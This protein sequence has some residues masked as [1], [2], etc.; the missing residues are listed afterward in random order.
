MTS[1][2]CRLTWP[3]AEERCQLDPRLFCCSAR[4][5]LLAAVVCGERVTLGWAA[6]VGLVCAGLA[7]LTYGEESSK[8][9]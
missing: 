7:L 4:P 6:G 1:W 2:V 9:D 3:E 5:G 8:E